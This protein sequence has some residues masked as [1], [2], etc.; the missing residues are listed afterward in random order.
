[1]IT[2]DGYSKDPNIVPDGIAITFGREMLVDHGGL[3]TF[4]TSFKKCLQADDYWIHFCKNKPKHDAIHVYL[5][6]CNR[7]AYRCQFGGYEYFDGHGY[8]AN[9]DLT[10][11]R[12]GIVLAGP[13]V[14]CP[15]KRRLKGF[16]GFRYTTKLF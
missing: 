2:V 11:M 4:L 10:Y 13:L 8:K 6:V 1:M 15:F 7:L 9:G 5:I 12:P 16:Q 14:R 3:K